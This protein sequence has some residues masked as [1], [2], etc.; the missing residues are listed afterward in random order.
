MD[1]TALLQQ[2]HDRVKQLFR[3]YEAAGKDIASRKRALQAIKAE[4]QVHTYVE[5]RVFYP[6]VIRARADQATECVREGLEENHVL[7]GLLAEIE[8]LE[9]EDDLFDAKVALLR[10]NVER[11]MEQEERGLFAQAR[12][13]LTDERLDKLGRQMAARRASLQIVA[14]VGTAVLV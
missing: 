7:D 8:A 5:E 6:A 9:P 14:S 11:H 10:Q 4:M 13:H 12:I 2:E 1:A 3:E